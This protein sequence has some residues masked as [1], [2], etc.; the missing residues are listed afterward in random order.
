M[1]AHAHVYVCVYVRFYL[2]AIKLKIQDP[3]M[4]LPRYIVIHFYT[5][6]MI[7]V[8]TITRKSLSFHEQK[9]EVRARTYTLALSQR[10]EYILTWSLVHPF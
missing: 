1:P 10:A 2:L 6:F 3:K 9:Y 4:L 5:S 8:L 7:P